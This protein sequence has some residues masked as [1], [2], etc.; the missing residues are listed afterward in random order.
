[1]IAAIVVALGL[2]T[3]PFDT[4]WQ[5]AREG[6]PWMPT[7][8]TEVVSCPLG[9]TDVQLCL[10][11][12]GQIRVT[13]LNESEHPLWGGFGAAQYTPL[14]NGHDGTGRFW[15]RTSGGVLVIPKE[16]ALQPG[17]QRTYLIEWSAGPVCDPMLDDQ[18][19]VGDGAARLTKFGAFGNYRPIVWNICGVNVDPNDYTIPR[20]HGIRIYPNP[21]GHP[22]R[23]RLVGVVECR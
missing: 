19:W 1:M 6:D 15:F 7:F 11:I 12:E 23:G 2:V 22:H 16:D 4:G 8:D 17:E 3:R 18:A 5:I 20:Q 10:T 9:T 21:Y 14:W 13:I